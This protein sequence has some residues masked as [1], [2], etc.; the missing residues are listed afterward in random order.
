VHLPA[1]VPPKSNVN[2]DSLAEGR[3]DGGKRALTTPKPAHALF[4]VA[5]GSCRRLLTERDDTRPVNQ[6]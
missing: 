6:A 3:I 2:G 1:N 5:N 4:R